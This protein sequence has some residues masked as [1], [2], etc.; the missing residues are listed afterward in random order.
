MA[1]N[2]SDPNKIASI[3]NSVTPSSGPG[4][5][6]PEISLSSPPST[7]IPGSGQSGAISASTSGSAGNQRLLAPGTERS[8]ARY[9][10]DRLVA[11]GGMASAY[12]ALDTGI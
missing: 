3:G 2:Y 4:G 7:S 9:K 10:I 8:N 11:A 5:V 12:R 6:L 1:S